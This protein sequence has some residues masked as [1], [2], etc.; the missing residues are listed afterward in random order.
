MRKYWPITWSRLQTYYDLWLL[1]WDYCWK[2]SI[3]QCYHE[4]N[5][6]SYDTPAAPINVR[7]T[8]CL[9]NLEMS[10]ILTAVR[11]VTKSR[12]DHVNLC[13]YHYEVLVSLTVTLVHT[14]MIWVPQY[15]LTWAGVLRIIRQSSGNFTVFWE[16]LPCN[17]Q[18]CTLNLGLCCFKCSSH[19]SGKF[20]QSK[21]LLTCKWLLVENIS[22][23]RIYF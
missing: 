17:M 19:N 14:R 23:H 21:E 1:I 3:P 13:F 16:W 4:F 5:I 6:C 2:S 7:V 22:E 11:D 9:K 10:R 18:I 8:T 12:E 20:R 15:H